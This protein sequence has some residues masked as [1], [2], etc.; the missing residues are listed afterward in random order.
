LNYQWI[1]EDGNEVA[2]MQASNGLD[3]D[4]FLGNTYTGTTICRALKTIS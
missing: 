4:H 3:G 2:F 1:D